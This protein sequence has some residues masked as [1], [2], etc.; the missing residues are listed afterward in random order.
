[1]ID[2]IILRASLWPKEDRQTAVSNHNGH[3][4]HLLWN[5]AM[6]LASVLG[7]A[8]G[9]QD[10]LSGALVWVCITLVLLVFRPP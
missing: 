10:I 4:G 1:V 2:W 8:V 3:N 9:T 7:V 5:A 6:L